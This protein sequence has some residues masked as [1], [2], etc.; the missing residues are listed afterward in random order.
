LLPVL[1]TLP[2]GQLFGRQAQ[3]PGDVTAIGLDDPRRQPR[4]PCFGTADAAVVPRQPQL[5]L[6][7]GAVI[8]ADQIAAAGQ[9][10]GRLLP[11]DGLGRVA[12]AVGGSFWAGG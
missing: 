1:L 4:Q 3:A 9:R 11:C 7:V 2:D 8:A 5:L 10:L 6:R 12:A